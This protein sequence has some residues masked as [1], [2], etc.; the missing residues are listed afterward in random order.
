MWD[1]GGS[2]LVGCLLG[3]IA[4]FLVSKNRQ[5]LIGRSMPAAEVRAVQSLLLS[6]PVVSGVLD[7]KTEELGPSVYRFKA[8]VA[9]NG[10]KVV[11]RYLDRC[12]RERLVSELQAAARRG[13]RAAIEVLL[14]SYGRDLISAVGAEVD[15]IELDIQKMNPGIIY[16]DLETDRGRHDPRRG[17]LVLGIAGA[18][19]AA[20]PSLGGPGAAAATAAA[21]DLSYT[22]SVPHY[23]A[24]TVAAASTSG[25]GGGGGLELDL[26][27]DR[28]VTATSEQDSP[29]GG[30]GGDGAASGRN[31]AAAAPRGAATGAEAGPGLGRGSEPGAGSG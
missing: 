26:N 3:A 10:D 22:C 11:E 30:S 18:A 13:D 1:A 28:W 17:A 2:I 25:G 21:D 23:G 7:T 27:Q 31:P 29:A 16:V 20:D 9:W 4:T 6:D 5:L 19:T 24:E 15:R 12:G 14:R 8:E